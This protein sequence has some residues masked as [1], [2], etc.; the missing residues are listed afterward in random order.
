M[1][2]GTGTVTDVA[3]MGL[4]SNRYCRDRV[5]MGQTAGMICDGDKVHAP[6][7]CLL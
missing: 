3:G 6:C 1:G 5:G 7:S 4:R 2:T